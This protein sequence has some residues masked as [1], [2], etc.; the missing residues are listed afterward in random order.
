MQNNSNAG[1][2]SPDISG[3]PGQMTLPGLGVPYGGWHDMDR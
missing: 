3:T 1:T 2:A